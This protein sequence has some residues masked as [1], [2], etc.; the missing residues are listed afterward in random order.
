MLVSLIYVTSRVH[1]NYNVL[2]V[3]VGSFN[4]ENI[5][6]PFLRTNSFPFLMDKGLSPFGRLHFLIKMNGLP[7]LMENTYSSFY[8]GQIICR[9]WEKLFEGQ[10]IW[11]S[12]GTNNKICPH[13]GANDFFLLRDNWLAFFEGQMA[14]PFWGTNGQPF[15]SGKWFALLTDKRLLAKITMSHVW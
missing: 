4:C 7:F 11:T 6:I 9:L 1:H 15:L 10:M 12:C 5:G 13:W 8:E 3:H 2:Y 14:S